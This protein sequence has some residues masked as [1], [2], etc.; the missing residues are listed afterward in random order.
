MLV[1]V[2]YCAGEGN[3]CQRE[4]GGISNCKENCPNRNF[5]NNIKNYYVCI[6][7]RFVLYLNQNYHG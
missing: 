7:A 4:C 6:F 1:W 2:M 5:S 3:K